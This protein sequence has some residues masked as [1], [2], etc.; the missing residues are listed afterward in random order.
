VR[1][2]RRHGV[3]FSI[4]SDAPATGHLACLRYGTG[5]AQRGW[6]TAEDVIKSWPFERLTAFL[7]AK[8]G[9]T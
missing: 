5:T 3:G 7:H 6:L 1:P 9:T 4:D 2:A 8:R